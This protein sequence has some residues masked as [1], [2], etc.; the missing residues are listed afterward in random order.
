MGTKLVVW[1]DYQGRQIPLPDDSTTLYYNPQGGSNY[2]ATAT[3]TGVR[4]QYLP[5]T[6]FS[7]GELGSG[8]FASLNICPYCQ[9]VPRKAEI[10]RVN[11]AHMESSPGE[12]MALIEKTEKK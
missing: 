10:A 4:S 9:P 7:Y 12:I 2:H 5:L 6:A 11:Q 1:E 8:A 3:C